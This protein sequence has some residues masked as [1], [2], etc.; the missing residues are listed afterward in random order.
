MVIFDMSLLDGTE[1]GEIV[2][3]ILLSCL[4]ADTAAEDFPKV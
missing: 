4:I 1:L 2:G 3:Q